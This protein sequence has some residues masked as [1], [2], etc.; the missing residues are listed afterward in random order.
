MKTKTKAAKI[1]LKAGWTWEEIEGVL[2]DRPVYYTP[3]YVVPY[4]PS[5]VYPFNPPYIITCDSASTDTGTLTVD[6]SSG[7]TI[8]CSSEEM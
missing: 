3:P 4:I 8:T 1:L 6:D 5:P 7:Y 2:G